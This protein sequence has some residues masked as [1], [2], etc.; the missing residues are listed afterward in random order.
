MIGVQARINLQRGNLFIEQYSSAGRY[1][2]NVSRS[3]HPAVDVADVDRR[4]SVQ[5]GPVMSIAVHDS[6]PQGIP[7][8]LWREMRG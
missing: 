1:C 7:T 5:T 2:L 4:L 8:L 6:R 3:R